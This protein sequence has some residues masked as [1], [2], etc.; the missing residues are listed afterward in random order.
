M[1]STSHTD[2]QTDTIGDQQLNNQRKLQGGMLDR[3]RFIPRIRPI[4]VAKPLINQQ[5]KVIETPPTQ[6]IH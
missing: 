5:S 6:S 3:A 4:Y 2:R 1:F